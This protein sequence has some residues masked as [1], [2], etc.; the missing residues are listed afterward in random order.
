M[1]DNESQPNTPQASSQPAGTPM[2]AAPCEQDAQFGGS[3]FGAQQP[4]SCPPPS[5]GPTVPPAGSGSVPPQPG[6]P[7]PPFAGGRP[8]Y[9]PEPQLTGGLKF[10]YFL[11][12]FLGNLFGIVVSWLVN[13]DKH[14]AI[15]SSA[16]K[17]SVIGFVCTFVV[18]ILL[19]IAFA[20]FVGAVLAAVAGG[21]HYYASGMCF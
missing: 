19:S 7:V 17:W 12:G 1:S 10:G 16:I 8:G 13:A 2:P 5:S 14:P 9:A 15:K 11:L 4:G 18:G 21:G 3:G 6:Q 20:G